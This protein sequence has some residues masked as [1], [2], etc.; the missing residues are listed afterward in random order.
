MHPKI[1]LAPAKEVAARYVPV[2]HSVHRGWGRDPMRPL[3]MTHWNSL[4]AVAAAMQLWSAQ[5]GSTHPT[6]M[7]S[8]LLLRPTPSLTIDGNF[9]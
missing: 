8:F 2:R 3:P 6:I 9:Q 7:L 5:R 1:V 4:M